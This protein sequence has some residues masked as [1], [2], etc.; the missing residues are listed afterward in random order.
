MR[1][2]Q[3]SS[4]PHLITPT[5]RFKAFRLNCIEKFSGVSPVQSCLQSLQFISDDDGDDG[6]DCE[7]DDGDDDGGDGDGDLRVRFFT[8]YLSPS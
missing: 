8:I 4:S 1:W 3:L 6:D 5:L 2:Q 7:D